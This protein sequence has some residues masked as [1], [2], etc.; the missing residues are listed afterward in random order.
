MISFRNDYSEIA[1]PLILQKLLECAHTQNNGYGLDEHSAA[2]GKS[3]W[4]YGSK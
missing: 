1:H 2:A 3:S 4:K